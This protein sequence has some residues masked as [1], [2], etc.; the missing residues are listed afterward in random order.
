MAVR[1]RPSPSHN[2][3]RASPLPATARTRVHNSHPSSLP[4]SR[5][6]RA[7]ISNMGNLS[8]I[9]PKP[10]SS[11]RVSESLPE[12]WTK[13]RL[14]LTELQNNSN[15]HQQS[16]TMKKETVLSYEQF[17]KKFLK[18]YQEYRKECVND[19]LKSGRGLEEIDHEKIKKS[20]EI[21]CKSS[22]NSYTIELQQDSPAFI[23]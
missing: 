10:L 6:A 3:H 18:S 14:E 7:S 15:S 5:V 21:Y 8:R 16:R 23:L 17:K 13:R 20:Y 11:D 22:Y 12:G 1:L 9:P 4:S 2:S 19:Y